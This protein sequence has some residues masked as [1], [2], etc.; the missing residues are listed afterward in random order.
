M[1]E[2]SPVIS[3][4]EE[5]V[6]NYV[7]YSS[8][9]ASG[10]CGENVTWEY[11]T[12]GTLKI[13]GEGAMTEF[14]AGT[15]PWHH[16]TYRNFVKKVFIGKDVTSIGS[17][18]FFELKNATEVVFEEGSKLESIGK[19]AF[20]HMGITSIELPPVYLTLLRQI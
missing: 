18:S 11:W 14:P 15:A 13:L 3:Q 8:A 20:G 4:A 17:Y 12:D 6:V 16:Y 1:A 5:Y 19:G 2:N 7:T 9:L 10:S